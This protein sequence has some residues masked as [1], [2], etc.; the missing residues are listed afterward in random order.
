L[1]AFRP[2][3][4]AAGHRLLTADVVRELCGDAAR[5]GNVFVAPPLSLSGDHRPAEETFWEVFNGRLLGEA[6]TRCRRQFETWSVYLIDENGER[7][8]EP[9]LA[10]RFAADTGQV[11]VTRAIYCHAYESYDA[12]GNVILARDVRKWQRELVG[13]IRLD[14]IGDVGALR[15]ELACLLF[16]AVVGTSR[17]P[18]TSA[19]APLPGFTLGRLGY[20]FRST[21]IESFHS[22]EQLF[23]PGPLEDLANIERIKR[24]DLVLR[25]TPADDLDSLARHFDSRGDEILPLLR[26]VFNAV[27]LSPYTDFAPKALAF[28]RRLARKGVIATE[29]HID[30]LAHLVRQLSRHL[31]AYDLVT[32]HHRGA[33]YPDA[34]LLDDLLAELL[35][36]GTTQADLF[37]GDRREQRLRRRA[38]RQALLL[39]LQYSGHAVPDSPTSPGENLRVLPAPFERVPEDQIYSPARRTRQLFAER[40]EPNLQLV[41]A[42]F[43]DLENAT[44]LRELG[45][46]LFLDRPF[47][48]AKRPGEPDQTLLASHVMFS[49]SI[50]EQR[51]AVLARRPDWLPRIDALSDWRKGLGEL[52]VDGL[53]LRDPGPPPRPGVVSLHD[54]RRVADDWIML[55]TTRQTFSDLQRQFDLEPLGEGSQDKWRLLAT[56]GTGAE[57]ALGVYDEDLQLR[58]QFTADVSDGYRTRGGVEFPAAGLRAFVNGQV[59]RTRILAQ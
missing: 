18:L 35:P 51:L 45:M 39:Q 34:L 11:F 58:Y 26:G 36:L 49:R 14:Q 5:L 4:C 8:G 12:G 23:G 46:A 15:D 3:P 27:S 16:Q 55:R 41:H 56:T 2:N 30:F 6:Q 44:E 52:A 28:V 50:A 43:R 17:L 25:A 21:G 57:P 29:Q 48:F 33:N 1:P 32:F 31:T 24:L 22:V 10:V 20:C 53:P 42:C 47:G 59:L 54:A 19:E 7:S 38:V 9:L 13:T 37:H 40:R